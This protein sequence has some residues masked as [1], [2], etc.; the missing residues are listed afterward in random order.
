MRECRPARS[1]TSNLLFALNYQ[2]A[3]SAA[4]VFAQH[5]A[6][7]ARHGGTLPRVTTNPQPSDT[8]RTLRVGYVSADL[9]SHSVAYFLEPLLEARDRAAIHVTCYS[10]STGGGATTDRLRALSDAW[11]VIADKDDAEAEALIRADQIDILV[12]LSGHTRGNRLPLF[13][14]RVAPI[15]VSY[16]GYPNTTG[17]ATMDYRLTDAWADPVGL[18]EGLYTEVLVRLDGGFLC[19]RPPNDSPPVAGP[20]VLATGYIT[21]GS[22]NNLAKVNAALIARWAAILGHVPG[23]R[24]ILK[25]RPLAD[26]G[27]RDFILTLS[28]RNGITPDRIEFSGWADDTR[29]HLARYADVDIALDTFPYHGTTTTCEAL[30]MGVPVITCG[31]QVHASRVG[32]SLLSAIGLAD[33]VAPSMDSYVMTAINL[34]QDIPR[35]GNLRAELRP[36]MA[37]GAIT[38]SARIARSVESAYRAMWRQH[39]LKR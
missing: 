25:S 37:A 23:S 34:A 11:R 13:A 39:C 9:R 14:R 30:W 10:N 33:L 21:F 36:R 17:L 22:F 29:S 18:T 5:L 4:D 28:A 19:Y 7:A 20:P 15:Q 32:V 16:L 2:E 27:I 1:P 35:L 12:D 38:D 3:A 26:P 31:G 24:L 6:W 8:E